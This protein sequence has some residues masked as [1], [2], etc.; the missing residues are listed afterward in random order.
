MIELF[1]KSD[2]SDLHVD[3]NG[4]R[5]AV[6]IGF[7]GSAAYLALFETTRS[8]Q[9]AADE[10]IRDWLIGKL[11]ALSGHPGFADGEDVRAVYNPDEHQNPI[12]AG[13]ESLVAGEKTLDQSMFTGYDEKRMNDFEYRQQMIDHAGARYLAAK[14]K[15]KV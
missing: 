15:T 9:E 1:N 12:T 10:G 11:G 6:G 14:S 2:N 7:V 13:V 4:I 8:K 3:M 5:A